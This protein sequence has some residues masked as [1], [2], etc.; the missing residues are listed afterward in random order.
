MSLNAAIAETFE[1]IAKEAPLEVLREFTEGV[2]QLAADNVAQSAIGV[3]QKAPPFELTDLDGKTHALSQLIGQQPLVV[4]FFRGSWCPFCNLQL[5]ALDRAWPAIRDSGAVL[6]AITPQKPESAPESTPESADE[7][8]AE[9]R[10]SFPV[11]HDPRNH[12]AKAYG[13]A[14]ELNPHLRALHAALDTPLP[15]ING[16]ESWT[17]P[18][19]ATF[20]VDREGVIA[21]RFLD[22]DYRIR[23]EPAEIIAQLRSLKVEA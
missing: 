22:T 12:V 17:L 15:P 23:S 3:G 16:D 20:V 10:P 5:G 7:E 2:A 1:A 8:L 13:L 4:Q 19:P 18:T 11:L 9:D 21:W 6:L 14:F